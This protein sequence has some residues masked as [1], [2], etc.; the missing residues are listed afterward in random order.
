MNI[1]RLLLPVEEGKKVQLT[2][3]AA[4]S[5][6]RFGSNFPRT[7]PAF[8]TQSNETVINYGAKVSDLLQML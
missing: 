7:P 2:L 6:R 8:Q 1:A 3:A 5:Y 4:A